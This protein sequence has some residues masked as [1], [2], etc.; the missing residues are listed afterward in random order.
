M[1]QDR[2]FT[3]S[4]EEELLLA[5][6]FLRSLLLTRTSHRVGGAAARRGNTVVISK[7]AV[8]PFLL[9]R[10]DRGTAGCFLLQ[11]AGYSGPKP[12][13]WERGRK[14]RA[15]WPEENQGASVTRRCS[16]EI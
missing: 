9:C 1:S 15:A 11:G 3:Q 5:S 10:L 4:M 16:H 13:R 6:R 7:E 12:Q 8:F 14:R 2:S